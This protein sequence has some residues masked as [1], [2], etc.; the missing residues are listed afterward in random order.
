MANLNFEELL[1]ALNNAGIVSSQP[2]LYQAVKNLINRNTQFQKTYNNE[3]AVLEQKIT[4]VLMFGTEA[5]RANYKP[6]L[7]IG[8]LVLFYATDTGVLWAFISSENEWF[9][10]GAPIDA[11]Y[12]TW[13]DESAR[14]PN[15]R[16]LV[17]GNGID[18]D[19]TVPNIRTV[20]SNGGFMPVNIGDLFMTIGDTNPLV[21]PYEYNP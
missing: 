8:N 1:V 21:I 2:A 16:N 5:N 6:Q 18:F 13:T 15:S 11:T 20:S 7:T 17:A 14:L 19:D 3:Q 9:P 10:V 4:N 12:I